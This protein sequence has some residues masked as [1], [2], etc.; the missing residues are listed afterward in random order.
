[1]ASKQTKTTLLEA[2]DWSAGAKERFQGD[3]SHARFLSAASAQRARNISQ[4]DV[5]LFT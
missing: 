4:S 1:M 3:D 2:K 5:L